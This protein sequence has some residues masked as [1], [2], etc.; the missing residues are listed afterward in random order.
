MGSAPSRNEEQMTYTDIFNLALRVHLTHPVPDPLEQSA[1][2]STSHSERNRDVL[3]RLSILPL[4]IHI[5]SLHKLVN[6]P[7][8]LPSLLPNLRHHLIQYITPKIQLVQR[9]SDPD[10]PRT[11]MPLQHTERPDQ[12]SVA[13]DSERTNG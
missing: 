1:C 5:L 3:A 10:S 11:Q 12:K 9:S 4:I 8:D 2:A 13:P 7:L 6:Q